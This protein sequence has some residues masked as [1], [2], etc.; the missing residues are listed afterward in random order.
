MKRK[1]QVK[2]I[3]I[4]RLEREQEEREEREEREETRRRSMQGGEKN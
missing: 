2:E 4:G 1:K 3:V